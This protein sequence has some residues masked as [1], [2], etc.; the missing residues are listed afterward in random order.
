[1]KQC[2]ADELRVA[3][4]E[5]LHVMRGDKREPIGKEPLQVQHVQQLALELLRPD[6]LRSVLRTPRTVRIERGGSPF[7]VEFNASS[8]TIGIRIRSAAPAPRRPEP[9]PSGAFASLPPEHEAP[10][11]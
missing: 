5:P 4:D 10:R 1:M 8:G 7:D 9:K 11:S 6:E 3:V 2:G